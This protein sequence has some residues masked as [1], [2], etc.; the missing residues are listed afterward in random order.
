MR[1]TALAFCLLTTTGCLSESATA[2]RGPVNAEVTLAPGETA[3]IEGA[4]LRLRFEGVTG[5]SR[6]PADAVCV[7]G[8][9][10]IVRIVVNPGSGERGY[11]LHTGSMAPVQHEDLTIALVRLEPYPFSSRTIRPEEY[12]ATLRVTRS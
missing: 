2:P 7:L 12:R 6:C 11:D 9:D 3:S 1:V 10:A 5:D 4:G 8:G